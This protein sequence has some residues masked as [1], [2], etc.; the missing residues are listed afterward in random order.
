M[1]PGSETPGRFSET[2]LEEEH[3]MNLNAPPTLMRAF[4]QPTNSA[5]SDPRDL[6]AW[7]TERREPTQRAGS[8]NLEANSPAVRSAR[9]LWSR[10]WK[11]GKAKRVA[12][13]GYTVAA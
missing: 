10:L 1:S 8:A 12:A 9:P 6:T 5:N 11:T 3:T 7:W 4:T 2:D 13:N